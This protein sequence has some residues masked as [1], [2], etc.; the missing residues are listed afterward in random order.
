LRVQDARVSDNVEATNRPMTPACPFCSPEPS[1]VFLRLP[2]VCALWDGF[3]VSEGHALIVPHRH[4]AT[5][6]DATAEERAALF[7]AIESVCGVIRDRFGADGFNVGINLGEAAGQTVPHLHLHVM[8]RRH[9]DVADP[10][11]GVRHVMP[12]KGNYLAP[13][14]LTPPATRLVAHEPRLAEAVLTTGGTDPLLP[15]LERD[16][17]EA[18]RVDIAVAFS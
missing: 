5:W 18:S 2:H 10:R 13:G 7:G 9:G 1:R 4:I 17:A 14:A 12:G 15:R 11:G 6:F 3:P 16:L 8:P